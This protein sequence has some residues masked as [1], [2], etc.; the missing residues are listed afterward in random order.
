MIANGDVVPNWEVGLSSGFQICRIF[1]LKKPVVH[2][3]RKRKVWGG[4]TEDGTGRRWGFGGTPAPASEAVWKRTSGG[5]SGR[6]ETRPAGSARSLHADT[7][8]LAQTQKLTAE[9]KQRDCKLQRG[10]GRCGLCAV[11]KEGRKEDEPGRQEWGA[12]KMADKDGRTVSHRVKRLRHGI[13]AKSEVTTDYET[14]R[15]ILFG[16]EKHC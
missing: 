7:A 6:G 9:D 14:K 12:A 11:R 13:S 3:E 5:E 8:E 15:M 1:E 10:P 2:G 16:V 4:R